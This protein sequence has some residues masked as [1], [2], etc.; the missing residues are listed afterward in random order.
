MLNY[1]DRGTIASNGVNG[2]ART[3]SESGICTAGSGIQYVLLCSSLSRYIILAYIV[4]DKFPCFFDWFIIGSLF[5]MQ[6]NA[7]LKMIW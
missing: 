6:S 2:S 3:C 1:I 4:S 5:C 7:N